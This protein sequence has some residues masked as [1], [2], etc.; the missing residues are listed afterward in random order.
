MHVKALYNMSYL[1]RIH[2]DISLGSPPSPNAAVLIKELFAHSNGKS[3]AEGWFPFLT[4][5][6]A[7]S[8][9]YKTILG[10]YISSLKC[11]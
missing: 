9:R 7:N 10:A 6:V 5:L 4:S 11:V 1:G 2:P 8:P 3:V